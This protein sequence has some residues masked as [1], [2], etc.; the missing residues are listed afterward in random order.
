[1]GLLIVKDVVVSFSK[2]HYLLL[3]GSIFDLQSL[4]GLIPFLDSL[5]QLLIFK[6][7][8]AELFALLAGLCF[9]NL[10]C[11]AVGW[12]GKVGF[13]SLLEGQ[14]LVGP[15]QLILFAIIL[16]ALLEL[17]DLL[18]EGCRLLIV[19]K[20]L[21]EEN[22][23]SGALELM[24]FPTVGDFDVFRPDDCVLIEADFEGLSLPAK[25]TV[26]RGKLLGIA[27]VELLV[28]EF[29]LGE[30]VVVFEELAYP[31]MGGED[32]LL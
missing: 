5:L 27:G 25:S 11:F 16:E 2:Q 6:Q 7:K 29:S 26:L 21:A 30:A 18:L 13:E 10:L 17:V 4:D 22:P 19:G 32:I 1:M 15:L 23:G 31:G 28:W 8:T 9:Q 20:G 3:Q 14:A 12:A 24:A